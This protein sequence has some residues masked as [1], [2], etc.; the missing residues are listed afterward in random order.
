MVIS[1]TCVQVMSYELCMLSKIGE[2]FKDVAVL[3]VHMTLLSFGY[4]DDQ[5]QVQTPVATL[6]V[7]THALKR[8]FECDSRLQHHSGE[9][10]AHE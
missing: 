10:Q 5:D 6:P 3:Y 9:Y 7:A 4:K 2:M 1:C 8:P